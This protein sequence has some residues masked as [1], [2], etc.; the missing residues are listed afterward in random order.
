MAIICITACATTPDPTNRKQARAFRDL[1]EA[2]LLAGNYTAAL[3]ELLKSEQLYADDHI[4][5]D[6]LGMAYINKGDLQLAIR[7]LKRAIKL[8]PGYAPAR[9]NLGIAYMGLEQW[10]AAIEE[11]EQLTQD[12]LYATPHFP[13]SNLGRAYYQKNDFPRAERYFKAA[14]KREP[15]FLNA[16]LGLAQ[17]YRKRLRLQEAFEVLQRAIQQHPKAAPLYLELGQVYQLG[18][19]NDR[20]RQ[21]YARVVELDPDGPLARQAKAAMTLLP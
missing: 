9:N 6:L 16:Q 12:M 8:K 4:L 14:L 13:L 10:D 7:H 17:T 20:A 5:Q 11:F 1:G 21:A 19:L 15:A 3:N 18:E 2:H